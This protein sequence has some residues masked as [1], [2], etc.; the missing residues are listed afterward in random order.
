MKF[1]HIK[2]IKCGEF[3]HYK[4]NRP[5]KGMKQLESQNQ[6]STETALMTLHVTLAVM[7]WITCDNESTVDIF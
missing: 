6:Q 5:G 7:I 2:C 4:S 1:P 3:G